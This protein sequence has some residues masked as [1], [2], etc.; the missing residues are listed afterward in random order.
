ML[1]RRPAGDWATLGAPQTIALALALFAGFYVLQAHDT[2]QADALE[3]LYVVPI[4]L[5]ALRFGLPGGLAGAFVA[6]AL[7]AVYDL[8]FTEFDATALGDVCWAIAFVLLGAVLGSFVD[9]RRTLEAEITR[10]FESSLDL[11]ATIDASGRFV[12][13]NPA[14]ERMLGY[15]P[16]QLRR[17][18]TVELV[19]PEDLQATADEHALLLGGSHKTIAFRNRFRAVDGDY[20]W[21]EWSAGT[22]TDGLIYA[23]ARDIGLQREAEQ[24]LA[25]YAHT[26]ESDVA[27]RTRELDRA[28]AETL[29]LLALAAE[30]RDDDTAEHTERVGAIVAEIAAELG[31]GHEQVALLR[32]ASP[33]HDVGKLAISDTILLKPGKLTEL[34]YEVM[35]TH[36]ARGACL[37]A[38][39]DAPVLQL[40]ADIAASHHERWDGGGYPSGLAGEE[41]P[42]A[43]RI[44]AVADVFDALTHDRPYKDAWPLERALEEIR[45][46][47]GS[48][49]DPAVVDAFLAVHAPRELAAATVPAARASSSARSARPR[50]RPAEQPAHATG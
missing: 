3:V 19:H 38:T 40:A 7:I 22:S 16:E 29:Q 5:L 39:A 46:G 26:L 27:E 20:R 43:G 21:L 44:V 45:R 18:V 2:H 48:Q 24:K 50:R 4:A 12:R 47:A 15:S 6:C 31:L 41:I 17:Y 32:E 25:E 1:R 33:L 30:Y 11:L 34:E 10:Y 8:T 49:F 28:R 35:K 36:A 9:R 14:C 42:L 23:T 13:V 37:L